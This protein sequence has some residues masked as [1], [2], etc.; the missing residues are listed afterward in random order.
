MLHSLHFQK[1]WADPIFPVGLESGSSSTRIEQA[2]K[3]PA[4]GISVHRGIYQFTAHAFINISYTESQ[5]I[6]L[7]AGR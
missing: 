3:P 5:R 7:G 4:D 1:K 2:A 6:R